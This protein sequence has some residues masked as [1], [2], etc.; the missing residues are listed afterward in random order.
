MSDSVLNSILDATVKKV[1]Q[2]GLS[3]KGGIVPVVKR[4]LPKKEETVDPARQITICGAQKVDKLSWL[5]FGVKRMEYVVQIV[6]ICPNNDD[7][8]SDIEIY[9][10]WRQTIR[11]DFA[12]PPLAGVSEVWDMDVLEGEFLNRDEISANYDY[13]EIPVKVTTAEPG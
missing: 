1:K 3:Y 7:Q 11:D 8:A 10:F 2:L 5:A 13:Q 6:I 12:E 9:S 4:K